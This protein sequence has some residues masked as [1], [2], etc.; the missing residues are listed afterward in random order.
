M[1]DTEVQSD[2]SRGYAQAVRD[3]DGIV[4]EPPVALSNHPASHPEATCQECGGPNTVWSAP[5]DIWNRVMGSPNGIVCFDCFVRRYRAAPL[6]ALTE[7]RVAAVLIEAANLEVVAGDP[8]NVDDALVRKWG[9]RVAA[10]VLAALRVTPVEEPDL[11][12]I[13]RLLAVPHREDDEPCSCD[14]CMSYG[15]EDA[16]ADWHRIPPANRI[17]MRILDGADDR[18]AALVAAFR[19]HEADPRVTP[20]EGEAGLDVERL[21]E[22]IKRAIYDGPDDKDAVLGPLDNARDI[23]REY[24]A[25]SPEEPRS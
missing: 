20:V 19:D 8:E 22:A 2:Y 14:E 18:L 6:E 7:E 12:A 21:A 23:A 24:A 16:G 4:S 5:N 17:A 9:S 1:G 25:L 11:T 10:R 15:A 3:R 13:D